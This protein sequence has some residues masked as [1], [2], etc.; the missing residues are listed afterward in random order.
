MPILS[1][2]R[3]NRSL[4]NDYGPTRGPNAADAHH[5]I[6]Y[7]GDP[8]TGGVELSGGGYARP[9]LDSDT[10]WEPAADGAKTTA[11]GITWPTAT[12]SWGVATYWGLAEDADPDE[13]W[14]I[15]RFVVPIDVTAPG[16]T[17]VLEAGALTVF[18][19]DNLDPGSL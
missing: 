17:V 7:D 14:D 10:D 11:T 12:T 16:G 4:D 1:V 6:L 15:G 3:R 8:R 2:S 13:V 18:Y 9:V 19:T 5:V